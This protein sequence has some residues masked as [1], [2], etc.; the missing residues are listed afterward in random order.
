MSKV[1]VLDTF[2]GAGG[3][4]LGFHMAGAEIIGA[5]EVDSWATET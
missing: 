4:S 1:K 2:A 3:F 5:I